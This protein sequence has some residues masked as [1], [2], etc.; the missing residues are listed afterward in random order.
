MTELQN[1]P[2]E[3]SRRMQ[4]TE[5]KIFKKHVLPSRKDVRCPLTIGFWDGPSL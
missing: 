5:F 1:I 3:I 2:I 4:K